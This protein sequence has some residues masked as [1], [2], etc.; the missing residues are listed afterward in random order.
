MLSKLLLTAF[1]GAQIVAGSVIVQKNAENAMPLAPPERWSY[2][3]CGSPDDLIELHSISI[4]P[5]PPKP[6]EDL[7]V[8]AKGYVKQTLDEGT[9]A[10]VLVKIGLIKLLQKRFDVCEEARN[11]NATI[12]CPVEPG[13]YTVVQ[14]VSLPKE[15][16]PAKFSVNVRAYSPDDE[17]AV[18]VNI[19][20]DFTP[21]RGGLW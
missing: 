15:I 10:D 18:C 4:K 19:K 9:Y 16:P 11:A 6:G 2:E 13:E 21:H 12:Q 3:D 7:E 20:V 5:D 1:L 14:T 17:D 8:T